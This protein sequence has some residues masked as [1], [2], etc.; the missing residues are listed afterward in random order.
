LSPQ[1]IG[2]FTRAPYR[3]MAAAVMSRSRAV[4]ARDELSLAALRE[5]APA[6]KGELT[7]DVA[8][9]LPFEDRG[10][11]RG[12][13]G[14]PGKKVRVGVNVSGLLFK[15]AE[16]GRNRFGLS[17]NYAELMTRFIEGLLTRPDVE[18]H[19]VPHVISPEDAEDDDSR[20][21][22]LLAQRYPQAVR[23]PD[24]ASPSDAKSYISSLDFLTAG[25]MHACIAAFS[26][27]TPVVPVAYSRKF[28]GLFQ[29]LDYRWTLPVSGLETGAA[30][31]Y[32]NDCLARRGEL[33]AD[34]VKGMKKVDSLLDAYRAQLRA[35]FQ[36]FA[37]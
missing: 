5:M 27:G 21:A 15:E 19:L 13:A 25:R 35:L 32:L 23:A 18:V 11:Q 22:D 4:M 6:A 16:T 3:Q 8:F 24:F 30:L 29:L 26:S 7:V 31:D 37:A 34:V 2:P 12:G 14:G 9:A 20:L 33:A 28:T 1:T 36:S 17:V 10:A